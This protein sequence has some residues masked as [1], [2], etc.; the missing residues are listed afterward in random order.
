MPPTPTPAMFRRSL[1]GVIP[2]PAIACRGTI[3]R[4]AAAAAASFKNVRRV[5]PEDGGLGFLDESNIVN[6]VRKQRNEVA[7][8]HC[9]STIHVWQLRQP[10]EGP[11]GF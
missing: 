1:G 7:V 5:V 8:G 10:L 3:V 2:D 11:L 4:P 9:A 6:S